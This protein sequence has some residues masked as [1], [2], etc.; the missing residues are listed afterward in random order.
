MKKS[1]AELLGS[2]CQGLGLE[3]CGAVYDNQE[4]G[5]DAKP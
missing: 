4:G 3:I 2:E 5:W 1:V